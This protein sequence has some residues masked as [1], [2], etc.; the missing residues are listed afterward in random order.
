MQLGL[1]VFCFRVVSTLFVLSLR[2]NDELEEYL[3]ALITVLQSNV[4]YLLI[5]LKNSVFCLPPFDN[6]CNFLCLNNT[7]VL[8]I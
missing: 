3:G 8:P 6:S 1:G 7:F 5:S 2:S 4:S